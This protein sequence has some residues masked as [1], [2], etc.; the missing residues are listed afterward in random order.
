MNRKRAAEIGRATVAILRAGRYAA[1]REVDL[2]EALAATVEA[3]RE[4]PPEAAIPRVPPAGHA[5]SFEVANESTLEAARRLA[6]E[7]TRAEPLA[8]N[9][10]SAK[11]PGG[12]FLSGARAQEE[13]LARASGLYACLEGRSMYPF[14]SARRDPMYTDWAIY[15]PGV[16]IFRDDEGQLLEEPWSCTFFT[17]PAPNAK[18]V[19]ARDPAR[20]PAVRAA[21]TAR[22]DRALAIAALH[23]HDTLV[24]GA[25]GCGVFGNDPTEVAGLF[26]DA[27]HG[28]F[29]GAFRHVAFAVLDWS[30]EERFIGPFMRRFA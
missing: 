28:A 30:E 5:T 8:L 26:H 1:K 25:W 18:V 17:C 6:A 2:R 23:A 4:Y 27:L 12:G 24:L 21:M 16:P 3:T 11:H 15:S 14:H 9:F 7:P 20:V 10:A 19:L 29:A 13:S 22:I